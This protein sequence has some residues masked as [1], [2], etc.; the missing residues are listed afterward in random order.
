VS[1]ATR[2]ALITGCSS[3]VGAACAESFAQAGFTVFATARSPESLTPLAQLGCVTRALDVT[4]V[5]SIDRVV[6]EIEREHGGLD[7][8]VN[9]A[10]YGQQ[11]AFEE[12]SLDDFRA[13]LETNLIGA[14]AVTQRVLPRM[15]ARGRGR[16]LMISSMGGR[17]A[18]PGGAAY[19]AS[20]YAL[21]AAADVLRFEVARFGVDVVIVEPGL[22]ASDYGATALARLAGGSSSAYAAF[23]QGLRAALERSFAGEVPGISTVADVAKAIVEAATEVPA[24][25]RVVVGAMAKELMRLRSTSSDQEWDTLLESMYPRPAPP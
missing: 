2:T 24:P 18:F 12:L 19:H 5:G 22:V 10:G 21:E 3:G 7:V 4:D 8:L 6:A 23:T 14:V 16:I 11:G 17:L 9:N 15:R 20:K 1:S 13:Q 25:T